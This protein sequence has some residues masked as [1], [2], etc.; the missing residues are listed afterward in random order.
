MKSEA[1]GIKK[2]GA[3]IYRQGRTR[4]GASAEGVSLDPPARSWRVKRRLRP[5]RT[6]GWVGTRFVIKMRPSTKK[7]RI[8]GAFVKY[9]YRVLL[10]AER[11]SCRW[12]ARLSSLHRRESG[13]R[14]RKSRV[15]QDRGAILAAG[16]LADALG[17]RRDQQRQRR[18]LRRDDLPRHLPAPC[19]PSAASASSTSAASPSTTAP[20]SPTATTA[21]ARRSSLRP[22][23]ASSAS[24]RSS[25]TTSSSTPT[26]WA[27]SPLTPP[28]SRS[29][30]NTATACSS[31]CEP[32]RTP[33]STGPSPEPPRGR[34]TRTRQARTT[35]R[36]RPNASPLPPRTR[37]QSGLDCRILF[38]VLSVFSR[39]L[40]ACRSIPKSSSSR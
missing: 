39:G 1:P 13:R 22:A 14:C 24:P 35:R 29:S 18:P 40:R 7:P 9:R 17:P 19:A 37:L 32:P 27:T 11:S 34:M 31:G 16:D 23:G 2:A 8:C 28:A 10:L 3:V 21:A 26:T 33:S 36:A 5:T 38:C 15:G 30:A 6:C 25:S 4:S 20:S 12:S